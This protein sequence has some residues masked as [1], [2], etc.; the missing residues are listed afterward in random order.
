MIASRKKDNTD[1]LQSKQQ[2]KDAL[3][4][5]EQK[6][7]ADLMTAFSCLSAQ[8]KDKDDWI[9]Q[10]NKVLNTY[11]KDN[12]D[13]STL[14]NTEHKK[15]SDMKNSNAKLSTKLKTQ[16][17]FNHKAEIYIRD[18][19][20]ANANLYKEVESKSIKL[21]EIQRKLDEMSKVNADLRTKITNLSAQCN[22]KGNWNDTTHKNLNKK[23]KEKDSK[24]APLT[25]ARAKNKS[26]IFF[27]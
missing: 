23:S 17:N 15:F 21:N 4:K 6:K 13:L 3:I 25:E 11:R 1:I 20:N 16:E 12:D 9:M 8:I 10:A 19:Q 14:F 26:D 18:I 24:T 7:Y 5:Y 27:Y 22:M 2:L